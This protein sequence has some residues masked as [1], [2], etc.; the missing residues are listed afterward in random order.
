MNGAT[1]KTMAEEIIDDSD[2]TDTFAYQ[3]MN[4]AKNVIERLRP[5]MMLRTKNAESSTTVGHTYTDAIDLPD[6]FR[7]MRKLMIGTKQWWPV[8]FEKQIEFKDSSGYFFID[9]ANN[10][11]YLCGEI[12]ES[13]TITMFYIKKTDEITSGSEP[14]WSSEFHPLIAFEMAYIMDGSVD[15]DT[16][17]FRMSDKQKEQREGLLDGMIDWDDELVLSEMD[18]SSSPQG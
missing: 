17:S 6:D 12:Q 9:V 7:V 8:P 5:W 14:V 15:A 2:W 11:L 3:L 1:I 13:K 16:I 10:D 4:K 18:K